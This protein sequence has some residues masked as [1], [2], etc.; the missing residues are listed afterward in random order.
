MPER[1]RTRRF[2][3]HRGARRDHVATILRKEP[4]CAF[5][6]IALRR[7]FVVGGPG[8]AISRILYPLEGWRSFI[9][10]DGC[11]PALAT[12]PEAL[13]GPSSNASLFG[14]A[15]DGVYL[16]SHVTMGTGELLPHP[17]TLTSS[18]RK[19]RFAFCGTCLRVTPTGRY[20]A[21]CPAE[22]GLSSSAPCAG[23]RL[24]FPG[25]W[26]YMTP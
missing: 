21:S 26:F 11:P 16:A 13:D 4:G 22:F 9:W 17:F 2:P 10:G 23:D 6:A 24:A 25:H 1:T 7:R 18:L 8:K 15:P 19:R 5:S 20:P 14:L 3:A 12:Y